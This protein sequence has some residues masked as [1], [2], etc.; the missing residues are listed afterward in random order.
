MTIQTIQQTKQMIINQ[1]DNGNRSDLS[2]RSQLLLLH[3]ALQ[4]QDNE[5]NTYSE[6]MGKMARAIGYNVPE[7]IDLSAERRGEI[8]A[9]QIRAIKTATSSAT[10]ELMD[11][12]LITQTRRGHRGQTAE[13]ALTFLEQTHDHK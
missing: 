12:G 4:V 5:D 6:G 2:P 1:A 9:Q 3:I 11:A 8:T 13:Y 7:H 10:R